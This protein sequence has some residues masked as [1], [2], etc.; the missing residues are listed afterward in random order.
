MY[1]S[2]FFFFF[3]SEELCI[4]KRL[5]F[6]CVGGRF[7][8]SD[9]YIIRRSLWEMPDSTPGPRPQKSGAL[10]VSHQ[11]SCESPHHLSVLDG[12][13]WGGGGHISID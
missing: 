12:V 7:P 5:S 11:I 2:V 6:F 4:P 10:P 13:P 8:S 9:V 1:P 3:A